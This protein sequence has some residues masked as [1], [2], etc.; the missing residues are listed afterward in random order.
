MLRN[1]LLCILS[2]FILGLTAEYLAKIE[3]EFRHYPNKKAVEFYRSNVNGLHHL[4]GLEPKE[5]FDA[6]LDPRD[7][8]FSEINSFSPQNKMNILIQGDSWGEGFSSYKKSRKRLGTIAEKFSVGIVN[9]AVTSYSPT[10]MTIQLRRLRQDFDLEPDVVMA[11]IDQTD[12]GDEECRY[13]P[14]LVKDDRGQLQGIESEG[15]E[16]R[17]PYS[18]YWTLRYADIANSAQLNIIKLARLAYVSNV[19]KWRMPSAQPGS[20]CGW[21]RI[22]SYL[23]TGGDKRTEEIFARALEGYITEVFSDENVRK[24]FMVSHPHRRHTKYADGDRYKGNVSELIENIVK[25]DERVIHINF[26]RNFLEF[27]ENLDEDDIFRENDDASHLTTIAHDEIY[28]RVIMD[29]ILDML[30]PMSD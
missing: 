2:I 28:L 24:L 20:R 7:F 12:I 18:T 16:N 22:I 21:A 26:N 19:E 9:A 14:S 25:H 10:P 15:P 17:E 11:I 23:V 5:W 30:D 1:S 6:N 29:Q 8:M 13:F 27:Y 3:I 4:R